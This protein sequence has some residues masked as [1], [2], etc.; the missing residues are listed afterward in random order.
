MIAQP[1]SGGPVLDYKRP[2]SFAMPAKYLWDG[3]T[4]QIGASAWLPDESLFS[5]VSRC[6][7]SSG[8]IRD[9]VTCRRFFG[10][11]YQGSSHDFPARL[12]HFVGATKAELGSAREIFWNRTLIPYYLATRGP[13]DRSRELGFARESG[14]G[15]VKARLGLLASRFGGAH[16]LKSCPSCESVDRETYGVAYWHLSHQYPGVWLCVK[17]AEPL[18]R[19]R[20]RAPGQGFA[21]WGLPEP[22]MRQ[23][24]SK[25]GLSPTELDAMLRLCEFTRAWVASSRRG[26][27]APDKLVS[28]LSTGSGARTSKHAHFSPDVNEKVVELAAA[29]AR[30]SGRDSFGAENLIPRALRSLKAGGVVHP[31][32]LLILITTCY[33]SF[34]ELLNDLEN[35]DVADQGNV[36]LGPPLTIYQ[37]SARPDFEAISRMLQDGVSPRAVA[38]HIGTGERRVRSIASRL[39][40]SLPG[41][42][43]KHSPEADD[44]I[45]ALLLAGNSQKDRRVASSP[46]SE[47]AS[48]ELA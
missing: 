11:A 3:V 34:N 38:A 7:V 48:P 5:Y 21:A 15:H 4:S 6:H 35:S 8:A 30:F 26:A 27:L 40:I 46:E 14:L 19:S 24:A 43:G 44:E 36:A 42:L 17:H 18:R 9:E 47:E 23:P 13:L 37:D 1:A 20:L 45:R 32:I 31:L 29:L 22:E 12:N 28:V 41:R 10:H 16:P 33:E 2:A 39:G 25:S